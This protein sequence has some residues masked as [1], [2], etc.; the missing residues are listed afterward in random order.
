MKKIHRRILDEYFF[1]IFTAFKNI[2]QVWGL[3][4]QSFE[5]GFGTRQAILNK[6]RRK[7]MLRKKESSKY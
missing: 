1:L 4:F 2:E 6:S 7:S 5:K 3:I